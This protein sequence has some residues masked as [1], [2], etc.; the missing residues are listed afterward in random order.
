MRRRSLVLLVSA[1]TLGV[2]GIMALAVVFF[3]TSTSAGRRQVR[4]LV[5]PFVAS[6]I[7]G[8]TIYIGNIG[9]N[10]I[11][12]I[13]VDSV[14]I[15]DKNGE[16]FVATGP[17]SLSVD[18][19]DLVDYRV[20]V[21]RARVERPFVH[22]I[23]NE[24]GSWNF[25]RIFASG[26][27]DRSAPRELK[28]RSFGDYIVIDSTWVTGANVL[29]TMPWH[30]D[31]SLR[32]AARDSSIRAHLENPAKYVTRRADG[33]ARTYTW[34][35][36]HG[37]VRRA[38]LADPDSNRFGRRFVID[39]LSV[40]EIEPTFKFRN[41]TGDVH[42]LGDTVRFEVAH[43]DMPA[44]TGKGVGRV[45]WGS[46]R[47][48]RYDI[49]I[50]GDS[51]S[52]DDVNWVYPDL[53]RTGGGSL[54]LVIRNDS[55]NEHVLDFHVRNMDVRSTKSHL[56]GNM[57]F[58]IG[59]PVLLV[60][61]V[62]M[63]A[64]P[65]DFDL[66]RTLNGKPFPL[67]W[68]GQIFGTV[69]ARG[70]PLTNFV[71]DDAR[72][73]Y[74]DKHV[75]GAVSRFSA[76]GE[77]DILRPAF[78]VFHGLEVEAPAVDLR[79]LQAV[80]PNFPKIGGIVSGRAVLDSSW[81]DVRFS[82]ATLVHQ[83]GPGEPSRF[84]GSGR[85]T[86]GDLLTYDLSLDAQP[87]SLTMLARSYPMLPVR[88]LMS[89]PIRVKGQA[90]DLE[91]ATS[92]QGP[93]GS[94]SF[95][96]RVDAD[97]IDGY[98]ARGRGNLASIDLPTLVDKPARISTGLLSGRYELDIA[99]ATAASLTG[100]ADI[101]LDS[102]RVDGIRVYRTRGRVSFADGR[103]HIVD[104]LHVRTEAG[105][106]IARGGLG[107]PSGNPDS[108][109]LIARIDSLG[110][111]RR[112]FPPSDSAP[113]APVD[114]LSGGALFEGML[115]G[116]MDA[117]RL[118]GQLA[119]RGLYA[120]GDRIDT[121]SARI[122]L[123]DLPN[124]VNGV[125]E[126]RADSILF[127]D[128]SLKTVN[129]AFALADP[130]HAGFTLRALLSNGP[131]ATARGSWQKSN[132]SG[133][134]FVDSLALAVAD[135]RWRLDHPVRIALDS[136]GGVRVDSAVLR[137]LD[138]ATV[139]LVADFPSVGPA[140]ARLRASK[141]PLADLG[142][143]AQLPDSIRGQANATISVA[144][145]KADPEIAANANLSAIEWQGLLIDKITASADYRTQRASVSAD[146]VRGGRTA[147]SLR[148]SL[149][150]DAS[151]LSFKF[152]DAPV[153]ASL[154]ADSTDL[155]IV[156]ALVPPLRA[157]EVTGRLSANLSVGGT[158]NAKVIDGTVAIANGSAKIDEAG[159]TVRSI[160]GRLIGTAKA[161]GQDSLHVDISG[162]TTEAP[163]GQIRLNGYVKN[164]LQTKS[165]QEFRLALGAR[166]FHAFNKRST[167]DLFVTTTDTI[168]LVG[169]TQLP[170]LTGAIRVDRGS[171]FLADREIA[172]KQA[173]A[174]ED[175]AAAETPAAQMFTTLRTNLR[176]PNLIITLGEDVR[177]R[178]AEA[179]VRL[180]DSLR[181]ITSTNRS[182]LTASTTGEL[183]PLLDIEGTL[184][185]AGGSYTVNLGLIAREFT[186]LPD[187]T[188]TFD[189][190][191]KN[192]V[193]DIRAMHNV[194]RPGDK[195]LGV[196]VNL[197]GRLLPYPTIDFTSDADY[198]IAQSDLISYLLI[199]R[200]GFDYN[201]Q[202]AQLLASFFA[203]TVSAYAANQLRR[204]PLGS[205]IDAFQISLGAGTDASLTNQS[206]SAGDQFR[207]L[208]YSSTIGAEKQFKDVYLSLTTGFCQLQSGQ[209]FTPGASLGAKAEYRFTPR[210]SLKASY[211]PATQNRSCSA[212]NIIGLV[213]TPPKFGLSLLRT[214]RF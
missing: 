86:Y 12:E 30:P 140:F 8:G 70:G 53:P 194:R 135:A 97:S 36:A 113:E 83:D 11:S 43:F 200:P 63:R 37:L 201:Q 185:T 107:L 186:V 6:K 142:L 127:G 148:G 104:S 179:N 177:L 181:V 174:I 134:V 133:T 163:A 66:L 138:S 77:L 98:A 209:T 87:L 35:N 100:F 202:Q 40:D 123:R 90:P 159:I 206:I 158:W 106:I 3:L 155:E 19:R 197:R 178:S 34:A 156:K 188:V 183:I 214:W 28:G 47:P 57:S 212:Q 54:E 10:F 111:L 139:S 144:G 173:V 17:V 187:G 45:W 211:D 58:G 172:R 20:F 137:N 192:P 149:P 99:G 16:V 44:S 80:N 71:V 190:D 116:T 2:L 85:I 64:D 9:G 74:H 65:M 191:P 129:G 21:R 213:P 33:F 29:L 39:T 210:L 118:S 26:T 189:G 101:A 81:L 122:D 141:V 117:F 160:N 42:I 180:T 52:L 151:N 165:Q 143:L 89:G 162:V 38:R 125:L 79:T 196:I 204:S 103:M 24:D 167:A 105:A 72:G 88:G 108:L 25:K 95:E 15:R 182:R 1:I 91:V 67:D 48:V 157:A 51:V 199:G 50:Q 171:I 126:G 147:V 84:S 27:D 175:S 110:G 82:D 205:W 130:A 150:L 109:T 166:S 170:T 56:V 169:T 96:G 119:G 145:T 146:A 69:K 68:Q 32:G 46:N 176:V 49:T 78:T 112:Y 76:R 4:A 131:T 60:R 132:G 153:T 136:T 193:L 161:G 18:W 203:P 164:L 128:W 73:T 154:T 13:T 124:R 23:Q 61:N 184:R 59:A 207:N 93:A 14:D 7:K 5:Q 102:T 208:L 62:D 198:A 31:D 92:L 120:A 75:A 22:I 114:S 121:L 115:S 152:R 94:F 41:V 195:D 55:K 168:R